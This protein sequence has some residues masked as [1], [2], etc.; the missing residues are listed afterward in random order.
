MTIA[1][2]EDIATSLLRGLTESEADLTVPLLERVEARITARI[3]D[4]ADRI[5]DVTFKKLVAEI[6][7]EAVARVLR[8]PDGGLYTSETEGEYSYQLNSVLAS[9]ALD[10]TDTEWGRLLSP[11]G[12]VAPET[13]GYLATRGYWHVPPDRRFQYSWPTDLQG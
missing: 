6:E 5:T 13:D 11:W 1:T 10:I 9:G 4:L 2:P 3:P 7:A 8:A 12:S